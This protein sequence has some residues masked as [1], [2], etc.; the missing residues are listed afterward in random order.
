MGW[1][2]TSWHRYAR[3]LL[4]HEYLHALG[5]WRHDRAFRALEQ[6]WDAVD[7]GIRTSGGAC[8]TEHL[9]RRKFRWC[10]VCP[11]CG[12]E[13]LRHRRQNGRFAC[14]N[15]AHSRGIKLVDM[16]NSQFVDATCTP[17]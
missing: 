14:A 8:F 15:A 10:W 11:E 12:R 9:V 6:A 3:F 17:A 13:H 16:P 5:F 7:D 1:E 2:R 4:Y